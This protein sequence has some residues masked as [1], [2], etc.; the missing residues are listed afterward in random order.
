MHAPTD[1]TTPRG[2]EQAAGP[3]PP[4]A[5][6]LVSAWARGRRQYTPWAPPRLRLLAAVRFTVGIF[7]V[8]LATVMIS[9]GYDGLAAV[10]LAGAA[11]LFSIASLDL[12]AARSAS[13]RT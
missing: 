13:P 7:L 5:S 1:T 3:T 2:F 4:P 6:K 10:P 8:G 11:L 9:H 12:A